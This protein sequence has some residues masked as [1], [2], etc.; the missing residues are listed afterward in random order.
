[1]GSNEH[2]SVEMTAPSGR[3]VSVHRD[4][5]EGYEAAG[6]T[7]TKKARPKRKKPEP[8][9]EPEPTTEGIEDDG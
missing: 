7:T 6:W 4:A 3:V 5:V 1:M 9:A 8:P 2:L